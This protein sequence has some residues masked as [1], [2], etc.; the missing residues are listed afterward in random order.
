MGSLLAI[1]LAKRGLTVTVYDKRP[2]MRRVD[3]S[4]GKSINL[5]LAERGIAG[6]ELAG[7]YE[8]AEPQLVPMRGPHAAS[9]R[10]WAGVSTLWLATPGTKLLG[11]PRM[12]SIS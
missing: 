11:I 8:L 6:L 1:L 2:D 12:R 5:A 10:W 3:I 9:S 4:A 7:V